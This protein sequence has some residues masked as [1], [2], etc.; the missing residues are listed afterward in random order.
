LTDKGLEGVGRIMFVFCEGIR[1]TP[2]ETLKEWPVTWSSGQRFWLL[3]TRSRVRFPALPWGFFL[4]GEDPHGGHDL[5]S[6]YNLGLRP[7]P[8]LHIHISPSTS[9]GQRNC[10]SWASQRQ[11]SVTLQPQPGGETTKSMTDVWQQWI[12]KNSERVSLFHKSPKKLHEVELGLT[13]SIDCD[14]APLC[15]CECVCVCVMTCEIRIQ[16]GT[17][18]IFCSFNNFVGSKMW[19]N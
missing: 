9:S 14:I 19:W 13:Q 10:A 6:S 12:K 18:K 1:R 2:I 11:K 15:V 4:I 3:I 7:L 8:V 16:K 5:G 17:Y